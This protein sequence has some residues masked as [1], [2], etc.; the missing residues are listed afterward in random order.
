MKVTI[1]TKNKTLA[2]L[3]Q[4]FKLG[5]LVSFVNDFNFN[6]YTIDNTVSPYWTITSTPSI[7]NDSTIRS[8]YLSTAEFTNSNK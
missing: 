1:D 8:G 3:D 5:E 7:F 4:N 6:D 2:I